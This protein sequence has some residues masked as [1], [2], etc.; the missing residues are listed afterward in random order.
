MAYSTQ[1]QIEAI[2]G[3]VLTANESTLLAGIQAGAD[4]WIDTQTGVSFGVTA[5]TKY[6]DGGYSV[7]PIDVC[8][9]ITA[10]KLVDPELDL[11]YTYTEGTEYIEGPLNSDVVRYLE[12]RYYLD[13]VFF[14]DMGDSGVWPAGL[15]KIAVTATFS[16]ADTA[17]A[18][19]SYLSAYLAAKYL[20][21]DITG[22]LASES[23]EGYSRQYAV[24]ATKGNINDEVVQNFLA[25]YSDQE[26]F[27]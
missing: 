7:L 8:R 15:K 5:S 20:N 12:K 3:R 4:L 1:A 25:A 2:L 23:I 16:Y 18:D 10:V 22:Q 17:P 24:Y 6:Y 14:D 13:N 9:D 11:L 21:R 19:I 26:I 27:F